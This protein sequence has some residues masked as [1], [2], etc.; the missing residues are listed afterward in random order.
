ME[1]VPEVKTLPHPGPCML[2]LSPWRKRRSIFTAPNSL[3][4]SMMSYPIPSNPGAVLPNRPPMRLVR[5]SPI[6]HFVGPPLQNAQSFNGLPRFHRIL[7]PIPTQAMDGS[8]YPTDSIVHQVQE[9]QQRDLNTDQFFNPDLLPPTPSPTS[10]ESNNEEVTSTTNQQRDQETIM[11]EF[12]QLDSLDTSTLILEP[13]SSEIMNVSVTSSDE[14]IFPTSTET[15]YEIQMNSNTDVFSDDKFCNAKQFGAES[16]TTIFNSVEEAVSSIDSGNFEIS[17]PS[18]SDFCNTDTPNVTSIQEDVIKK[19][20]MTMKVTDDK[21]EEVV[22]AAKSLF[23]KRTRTLYHWLYPETSKNKL[24]AT[25]SAAWDTLPENEKHFY[26]SQVLG[27]FG[28]QASSLMINPQLGGM[29]GL[30]T[31][32]VAKSLKTSSTRDNAGESERAVDDLFASCDDADNWASYPKQRKR[33]TNERRK[34]RK[35]NRSNDESGGRARLGS[36]DPDDFDEETTILKRMRE[37]TLETEFEEDAELNS[38]L[39][40]FRLLSENMSDYKDN[41]EDDFWKRTDPDDLFSQIDL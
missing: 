31:D 8:E 11:T 13:Q 24:K 28:L 25:V 29:K 30:P 1:G 21:Q 3:R 39:E 26:I 23:S 35:A 32:L 4:P 10:V 22:K 34:K 12:Q 33:H 17:S 27:R 41:D 19:L 37:T 18:S 6:P 7:T 36:V 40:K 14:G 5:L 15:I 2:L 38:E 20:G 9:E 16:D